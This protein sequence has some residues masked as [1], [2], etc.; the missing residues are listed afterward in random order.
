VFLKHGRRGRPHARF[1]WFSDRLDAVNWRELG[2]SK[3]GG[4]IMVSDIV[5]VH[6]G[7]TTKVF[8]RDKAG[9]VSRAGVE[10]ACFA[11][12]GAAR[13]L[14]LE[15]DT[16]GNRYSVSESERKMRDDWVVAIQTVAL[17]GGGRVGGGRGGGGGGEEDASFE[18]KRRG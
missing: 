15:V 8:A 6:A 18:G 9:E 12:I 4:T 2:K 16:D 17:R 10:G 5:E 13:T 7:R 3:V 14:D 11:I 1:V